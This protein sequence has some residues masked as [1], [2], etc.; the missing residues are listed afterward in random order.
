M[1]VGALV[2]LSLLLGALLP[3]PP[4]EAE[5]HDA[6]PSRTV[7]AEASAGTGPGPAPPPPECWWAN[8]DATNGDVASEQGFWRRVDGGHHADDVLVFLENGTLRRTFLSLQTTHV[9]QVRVCSDPARE[10]AGRVR[11]SVVGPPNPTVYWDE[12][13]ERVTRR[14]PLPAPNLGVDTQPDGSFDVAVNLGLWIAVDNP[15]DVVARA[16]PAPGVWAE[17]RATLSHIEF[18]SGTGGT[19]G[20]CA[21][22]G[23]P[24]PDS[25][26]DTVEQGPCGYIYTARR[27]VGHHT[28]ILR[29]TW[30]VTNTA[31]T[32][33][34]E[35]RPDIVLDTL[36]PVEVYEIQTVGTRG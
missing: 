8:V 27:E 5:S 20:R 12:L 33:A 36:I 14:V 15:D 31:S 10:E 32:G 19:S 34:S 7:E 29:A 4:A 26:S 21:G 11:W 16:A 18:L 23:T 30:T 1:R 17:T 35:R 9:L 6:R 28:A 13:T 2:S 24:L 22:A 3:P 25:A